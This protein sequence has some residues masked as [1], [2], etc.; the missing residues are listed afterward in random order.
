[1]AELF[2]GCPCCRTV[3]V[4]R[5]PVYHLR[6]A[7]CIARGVDHVSQIHA[8]QKQSHIHYMLQIL[9]ITNQCPYKQ[10]AYTGK[11]QHLLYRRAS[12]HAHHSRY[13][14]SSRRCT[15]S[16]ASHMALLHIAT[17]QHSSIGPP[18][19]T[20]LLKLPDLHLPQPHRRPSTKHHVY[21][22]LLSCYLRVLLFARCS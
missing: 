2:A 14:R 22:V 12:S 18:T 1:V 11:A 5:R 6:A 21:N 19:A 3:P 7:A 13:T 17:P 9:I 16:T 8:L 4:S 15:A 20:P 10:A